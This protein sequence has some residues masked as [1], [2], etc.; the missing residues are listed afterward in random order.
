MKEEEKMS[1]GMSDKVSRQQRQLDEAMV[2]Q[3][4]VDGM[5]RNQSCSCGDRGSNHIE[6][7]PFTLVC[8]SF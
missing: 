2:I 4:V 3:S 7:D 1:M 8:L 6:G 5:V